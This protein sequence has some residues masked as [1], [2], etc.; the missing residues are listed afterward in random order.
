VTRS[1]GRWKGN[2]RLAQ[3]A[4]ISGRAVQAANESMKS[5]GEEAVSEADQVGRARN[6]PK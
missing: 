3:V 5:A 4:D 1:I 2:R 6:R